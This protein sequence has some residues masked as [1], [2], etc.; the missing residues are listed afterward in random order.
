[1]K[2]SA[3]VLSTRQDVAKCLQDFL[4]SKGV[5]VLDEQSPGPINYVFIYSDDPS[6]QLNKNTKAHIDVSSPKIVVATTYGDI[7][8]SGLDIGDHKHFKVVELIRDTPNAADGHVS[9][10]IISAFN[11]KTVYLPSDDYYIFHLLVEQLVEEMLEA[12]FTYGSD[13]TFALAQKMT[14]RELLYVLSRH[15]PGLMISID[16]TM[17]A[18]A[19]QWLGPVK[20][21]KTQNHDYIKNVVNNLQKEAESKKAKIVA[22]P[23][24]KPKLKFPKRFVVA[25]LILAGIMLITPVVALV[26]SVMA[27]GVALGYARSFDLKNAQIALGMS[28]TFAVASRNI[29]VGYSKVPVIKILVASPTRNATALSRSVDVGGRVLGL[30]QTAK[31][32]PDTIMGSDE[33]DI[34]AAS[35]ELYLELDALYRDL[36]FIQGEWGSF[37]FPFM[38]SIDVSTIEKYRKY[39]LTARDMSASLPKLLGYDTPKT[40]LLLLQNN[41]ELRPTG[42]FIGSFALVTFRN[43]KMIDNSIYDVYS[44]DGQLKGYVEPP[45]PISDYLGEASWSLRDSNWDPDFASSA[46]RAEWF[47]DKTLDREVDGVIGVNLEVVESILDSL[48][49]IYL[50]DFEDT[51]TSDN[52]YQRVQYEVESNFFPGSR[53]KANYL[54]S[55]NKAVLTQIE[56]ANAKE[57]A[58]LGR[59]MFERLESKDLQLFL[60]DES[61]QEVV[62]RSKWSGEVNILDCGDNC[63]NNFVG[64]VEANVGVNKANYHVVRNALLSTSYKNGELV[65]SLS[66]NITNTETGQ[67]RI[68][69]ERYK[70]Y[71]RAIAPRNAEFGLVEISTGTEQNRVVADV[72]TLEARREAGVIVE[73]LPEQT[74]TVNFT[75]KL[76]AGELTDEKGQIELTWWKQSGVEPFSIQINL[77]L[78]AANTISSDPPLSLT[79]DMMPGY[80]TIL[81]TDKSFVVSWE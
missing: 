73:V 19:P 54:S 59:A 79:E 40:Y 67:D 43:G 66:I 46:R 32:L 45:T 29:L 68:P 31:N 14:A 30:A 37:S 41:M 24:R 18:S 38:P 60:H 76:P 74:K 62:K 63:I 55:L 75:W 20:N 16:E 78:P 15:I 9:G 58:L 22:K 1:M 10:L 42:G 39:V 34:Q 23:S 28:K 61:A 81:S 57:Y 80:N 13:E 53:K 44:A 64:F 3:L 21:P 6:F 11:S 77:D 8:N 69:E 36:S 71:V 49:E 56:Q 2:P 65:N 4:E 35:Q 5:R 48:G 17:K 7:A 25:S 70:T 27:G 12:M 72:S 50:V 47:L 51:I 33:A 52:V 26:G